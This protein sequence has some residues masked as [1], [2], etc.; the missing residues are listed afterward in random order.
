MLCSSLLAVPFG[1]SEPFFLLHYWH[2]PS[3]FNLTHTVHADLETFLFCFSIGGTAAVGYHV[4]TGRPLVLR[5]R[6]ARDDRLLAG[7]CA[8]LAAPLPLSAPPCC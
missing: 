6:T 8:A 5:P 2:P 1:F 7:Y 4:V 3:L